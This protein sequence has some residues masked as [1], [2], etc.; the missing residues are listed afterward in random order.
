MKA[1]VLACIMAVSFILCAVTLPSL[2]VEFWLSLAVF[3]WTCLY[4]EKHADRLSGELDEMF[5]KDEELK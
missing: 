2:G 5:G 3:A 1:K 4:A